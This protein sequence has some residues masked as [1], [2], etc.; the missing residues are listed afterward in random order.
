MFRK[1][2]TKGPRGDRTSYQFILPLDLLYTSI[3]NQ[4]LT[5]LMEVYQ[6]VDDKASAMLKV[7]LG[8]PSAPCPGAPEAHHQAVLTSSLASNA[9]VII[10][11]QAQ[12]AARRGTWKKH[13]QAL[14]IEKSDEYGQKRNCPSPPPF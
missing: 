10:V 11:D 7:Q 4:N 9:G 1:D 13:K 2:Q 6:I 3:P 5:K 14:Y 8:P 12:D